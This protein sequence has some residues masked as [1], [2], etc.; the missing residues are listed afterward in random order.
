MKAFQEFLKQQ[1]SSSTAPSSRY[2]A[3]QLREHPGLAVSGINPAFIPPSVGGFSGNR[4]NAGMNAKRRASYTN[5]PQSRE[6]RE[7]ARDRAIAAKAKAAQNQASTDADAMTTARAIQESMDA[8]FA[9]KAAP[10]WA[11]D[12]LRDHPPE[13]KRD[14][15]PRNTIGHGI[16]IAGIPRSRR[17]PPPPTASDRYRNLP[18]GGSGSLDGKD[19]IR[20]EWADQNLDFGE[21]E[22]LSL[23]EI[24]E[25]IEE[26]LRIQSGNSKENAPEE[27]SGPGRKGM[28]PYPTP[29]LP[30]SSTFRE[31]PIFQDN[32]TQSMIS[33]LIPDDPAYRGTAQEGMGTAGYFGSSVFNPNTY[34]AFNFLKSPFASGKTK[35]SAYRALR[36]G[37]SRNPNQ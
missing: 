12:W 8:R 9:G 36:T 17:T 18:E 30:L 15:Q 24:D 13:K 32:V 28:R 1:I 22:R 37:S 16:S 34:D 6:S 21:K 5:T 2:T 23:E 25:M 4:G 3:R 10:T 20:R 14:T 29:T 19:A 31:G 27:P 11:T 7:T 33:G 35:S 26:Q